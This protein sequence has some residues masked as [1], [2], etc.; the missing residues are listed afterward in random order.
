M[1]TSKQLLRYCWALLGG[2]VALLL[3]Y[4]Y[5]GAVKLPDWYARGSFRMVFNLSPWDWYF[6]LETILV[7][8]IV[9]MLMTSIYSQKSVEFETYK[10]KALRLHHADVQANHKHHD[11]SANGVRANP[12]EFRYSQTQSYKGAS[13]FGFS[14]F[15]NLVLNLI[16]IVS[17]PIWLIYA[18]VRRTK[19]T[20][21]DWDERRFDP[22]I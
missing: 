1:K 16:V 14:I 15:K 20:K 13:D 2:F 6:L 8:P 3:I 7:V 19:H 5:D 17:G 18:L 11:W 9:R 21:R 12:L 4:L 10:D 22:R